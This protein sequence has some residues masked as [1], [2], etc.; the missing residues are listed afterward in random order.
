MLKV[1]SLLFSLM[2]SI[3]RAAV[4][5]VAVSRLMPVLLGRCVAP[6]SRILSTPSISFT[7]SLDPTITQLSIDSIS[8]PL[9]PFF[10]APLPL[11][12]PLNVPEPLAWT[13]VSISIKRSLHLL[14]I[15]IGSNVS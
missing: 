5:L 3:P 7:T 8:I 4:E 6:H 1:H 2:V 15:L 12:R 13:A 11:R 9:P 14:K 10:T